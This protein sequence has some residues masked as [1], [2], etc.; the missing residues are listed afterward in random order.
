M[1]RHQRDCGAVR[2]PCASPVLAPGGV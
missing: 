1:P 2:Q